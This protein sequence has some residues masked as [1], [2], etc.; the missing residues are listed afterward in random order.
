M[1]CEYIVADLQ[2]DLYKKFHATFTGRKSIVAKL[3]VEPYRRLFE[4][5]VKE[6]LSNDNHD[7]W[8]HLMKVC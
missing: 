3:R 7:I 1:T 4:R 6:I 2:R 5:R 8:G